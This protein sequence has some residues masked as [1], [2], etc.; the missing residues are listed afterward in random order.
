VGLDVWFREDVER[1]IAAVSIAGEGP[2]RTIQSRDALFYYRLGYDRAL[3]AFAAGFGLRYRSTCL[4]IEGSAR[5]VE[6]H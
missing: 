5:D 4:L 2:L 6:E 1:I 3:E